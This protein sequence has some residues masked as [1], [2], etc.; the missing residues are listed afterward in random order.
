MDVDFLQLLPDHILAR[1]WDEESN[2]DVSFF[3]PISYE[4]LPS[5]CRACRD[6]SHDASDS[7]KTQNLLNK[8]DETDG[9]NIRINLSASR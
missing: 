3:V 1:M 6:F 4:K 8:G 2:I 9:K 7:K 5:F